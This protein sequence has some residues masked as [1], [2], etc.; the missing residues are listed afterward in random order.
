MG[1]S[2]RVGRLLIR[3]SLIQYNAGE[4][5]GNFGPDAFTVG[6]ISVGGPTEITNSSFQYNTGEYAGAIYATESAAITISGGSFHKNEAD[7]IGA[8]FSRGSLQMEDVHVSENDGDYGGAVRSHGDAVLTGI[9]FNEN[10]GHDDAGAVLN[11]AG[12]LI[13]NSTFAYNRGDDYGSTIT[14]F[15]K[16]GLNNVTLVANSRDP[17]IYHSG[18]A[19]Y[20]SL[21]N[22]LMLGGG[23]ANELCSREGEA[24]DSVVFSLFDD[25]SCIRSAELGSNRIEP[26]EF[27][28]PLA[29]NGGPTWTFMPPPG[30]AAIDGGVCDYGSDQRGVPRPQGGACDIGAVEVGEET[31]APSHTHYLPSVIK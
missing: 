27:V 6:G 24:P 29:D 31:A 15:G 9:I 14:N 25:H 11:Y 19:R 10:R 28:L 3:D 26:K 7:V 21:R 1:R 8:I 2:T 30:S 17:A 18:K 5:D 4:R 22:V 20:L 16:L 13:R 12:M 23:G